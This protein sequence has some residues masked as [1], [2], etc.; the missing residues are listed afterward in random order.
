[1]S[2]KS[3]CK[4]PLYSLDE[5]AKDER[6]IAAS[7]SP[8][9]KV[10]KDMAFLN[11]L[12]QS[13]QAALCPNVSKH[14]NCECAGWARDVQRLNLSS[15]DVYAIIL[16][17]AQAIVLSASLAGQRVCPTPVGRGHVTTI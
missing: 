15:P 7:L 16:A 1:M 13:L 14:Q 3:V 12:K 17:L 9:D 2:L 11:V 8:N 6:I 5:I 4:I 10:H